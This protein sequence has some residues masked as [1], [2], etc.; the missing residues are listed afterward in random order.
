M[1]VY[2]NKNV[3]KFKN[4]YAIK[5]L[6]III[7]SLGL[8]FLTSCQQSSIADKTVNDFFKYFKEENFSE[9]GNMSSISVAELI[10]EYAGI[11]IINYSVK[12]VS[13]ERK[14][15]H[16]LIVYGSDD[17]TVNALRNEMKKTYIELYPDYSVVKDTS[18][19]WILQSSEEILSEYTVTMDVEYSN[20]LGD[21]KRNSVTVEVAQEKPD[22]D[23]YIVAKIIGII[24]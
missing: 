9:M 11:N 12:S 20:I 7:M 6:S 23:K 19:E 14:I 17:A 21:T 10:D 24:N 16:E 4:N 2:A 15:K 22:S 8:L 18:E 1:K 5:L 3:R 13:N